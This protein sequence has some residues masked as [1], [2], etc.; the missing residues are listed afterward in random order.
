V[1]D[2]R[3]LRTLH[4]ALLLIAP[5]L[6]ARVAHAAAVGRV[7]GA[8][9]GLD[10]LDA[11]EDEAAQRFQPLWA[12][13]AHLLAEAGRAEEAVRAYERVISLTTDVGARRYFERRCAR[14]RAGPQ[15]TDDLP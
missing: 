15:E 3:A 9:A 7:D 4:A 8:A 2:W 13:R 10:A 5:T 11:I 12:T 14:M 6:G 1:T